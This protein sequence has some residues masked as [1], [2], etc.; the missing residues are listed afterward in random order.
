MSLEQ[1]A[2]LVA[3]AVLLLAAFSVFWRKAPKKGDHYESG[4][5]MQEP[6]TGQDGQGNDFL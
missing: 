1:I 6:H 4:I 2:G 5:G 3:V